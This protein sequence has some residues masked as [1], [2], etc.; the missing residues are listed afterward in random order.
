MD[1]RIERMKQVALQGNIDGFYNLIRE[2]VKLLEHIDELPFVDTP[3]HIATSAGH[4]TFSTEMIGLKPSFARKLNPDGFSPIHIALQKKNIEMVHRLLQ[5]DRDL[6]RV[7]GRERI[8]PLHYVVAAGDLDLL[9]KFLLVCPHSIEDVSIRNET[10]LHIALIHNNLEAFRFLVGW[11]EDNRFKNASSYERKF[12]NWKDEKGD[13]VLHIA[14]SQNQTQA[15]RHLLAWG[16]DGINIKNLEG[17]TAW[18]ISQRRDNREIR[19]MLDKA[20]ALKASP[21]L[22]A[23]LYEYYLRPPKFRWAEYIRKKCARELMTLSNERRNALLVIVALVVTVTYQAVLSPPG[24]V[25]QD[26]QCN[27]IAPGK[28]RSTNH[29]GSNEIQFNTTADQHKE[30]SSDYQTQCSTTAAHKAGRAILLTTT[31]FQTFLVFNSVTFVIS[32]TIL[33]LL[34]PFGCITILTYFLGKKDLRFHKKEEAG[35]LSSVP[36]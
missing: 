34:V 7:K 24:G 21:T 6:V 35:N 4:I 33:A 31:T 15:V 18:D 5:L 30:G 19:V 3:L 14:V 11:L 10:A 13:T 1:E 9:E 25:W 16:F 27:T 2:D 36:N 32:S 17:K 23:N 12:L 29:L 20:R 8:T 26:D 28:A 22:T